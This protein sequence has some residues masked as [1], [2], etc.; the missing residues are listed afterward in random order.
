MVWDH[1]TQDARTRAHGTRKKAL[2]EYEVPPLD[3]EIKE[4]LREF[5]ALKKADMPDK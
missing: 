5:V 1:G 2:A 3:E 4:A